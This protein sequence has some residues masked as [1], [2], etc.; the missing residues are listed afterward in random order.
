MAVEVVEAHEMLVLSVEA[1]EEVG[2]V[3][4]MWVVKEALTAEAA[5]AEVRDLLEE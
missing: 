1:A 2:W 3:L 5:V 4:R